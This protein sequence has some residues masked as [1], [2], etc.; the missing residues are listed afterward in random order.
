MICDCVCVYL[1]VYEFGKRSAASAE[2]AIDCDAG[3]EASVAGHS[4]Q[5]ARIRIT[6]IS[7]GLG[8]PGTLILISSGRNAFE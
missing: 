5:I 3:T 7:Q 6:R 1:N 2:D 4:M 8:G